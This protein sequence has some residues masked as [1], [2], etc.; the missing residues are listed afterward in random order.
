VEARQARG[1]HAVVGHGRLA[2]DDRAR[3][4]HPRRRRRVVGRGHEQLAAVPT[5]TGVPRVAMFSL[6]VDGTP[7]IGPS[8]SPFAQRASE[9]RAA[10]APLPDRA[11]RSP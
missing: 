2:E 3:L 4:A 10:A 7:S 1:Q 9:A 8:G 6:I 11:P 5:G